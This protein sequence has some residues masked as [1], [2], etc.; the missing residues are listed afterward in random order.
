MWL[1]LKASTKAFTAP[2]QLLPNA[3]FS[4]LGQQPLR[5]VGCWRMGAGLWICR[6]DVAMIRKT[7]KFLLTFLV[8]GW[9]TAGS[10]IFLFIYF[11]F[12][13]EISWDNSDSCLFAVLFLIL[14][15]GI[16]LLLWINAES[17]A[18]AVFMTFWMSV[19][20]TSG[21]YYEFSLFLPLKIQMFNIIA[22]CLQATSM[23]S[24]RI[25]WGLNLLPTV[26]K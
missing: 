26:K 15:K 7:A 12:V 17:V 16:L 22:A 4:L 13:S 1:L 21:K 9:D 3:P 6:W 18:R 2:F 25:V 23:F 24:T 20:I 11:L 14:H 19:F 10:W 8:N 5:P